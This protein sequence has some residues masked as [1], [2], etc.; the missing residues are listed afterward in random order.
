[1]RCSIVIVVLLA[2]MQGCAGQQR[3]VFSLGDFLNA[4][5]LPYDSPLQIIYRIDDHRFVTLENY[6]DCNYGQAYY[7][8]TRIGIKTGLGRTSIEDYQGRLINADMTGKI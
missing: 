7:N 8:D 3:Q 5:V 1:M 2:L 6:R 4:K